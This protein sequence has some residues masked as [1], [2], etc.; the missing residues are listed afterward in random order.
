MKAV[1]NAVTL[2]AT[3][4]SAASAAEI[5][6]FLGKLNKTVFRDE[7]R[8]SSTWVVW[9]AEP[10]TVFPSRGRAVLERSL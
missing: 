5:K 6:V 10:P 4:T 3:R 1:F 8:V 2:Y 7:V 9:E